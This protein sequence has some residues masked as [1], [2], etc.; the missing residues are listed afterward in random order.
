MCSVWE[1]TMYSK[2]HVHGHVGRQPNSE[3]NWHILCLNINSFN[4][5][6]LPG[7]GALAAPDAHIVWLGHPAQADTF[8][9]VSLCVPGQSVEQTQQIRVYYDL[10][11]HSRQMQCVWKLTLR[12]VSWVLLHGLFGKHSSCVSH[13]NSNRSARA[14]V[15]VVP[16][17]W[18]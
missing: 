9:A 14:A 7:S 5:L 17:N 8:P 4:N 13:S 15:T 3:S 6:Y 2:W 12:G 1:V 16:A 18:S 11:E 10:Y